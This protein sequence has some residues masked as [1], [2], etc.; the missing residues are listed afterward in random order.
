MKKKLEDFKD[1][2]KDAKKLDQ[3]K[4]GGDGATSGI[5]IP[6]GGNE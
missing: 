6:P 5:K 2:D 3:V 1:S 4:G